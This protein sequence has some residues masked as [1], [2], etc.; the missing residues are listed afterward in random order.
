MAKR[1]D[2]DV[3]DLQIS[4]KE[5]Q[6][7]NRGDNGCTGIRQDHDKAAVVPVCKGAANR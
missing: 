6:R 2:V 5:Q 1:D 3:P 4:E 7:R